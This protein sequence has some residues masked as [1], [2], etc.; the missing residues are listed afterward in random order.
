V[1]AGPVWPAFAGGAATV[2]RAVAV[3][4]R[5]GTRLGFTDHDGELS[6]DGLSFRPENGAALSALTAVTGLG[7]DLG[8]VSG[9]LRSDALSEADLAAGRF[10]GAEV[11]VWLVNWADPAQRT[12]VFRGEI[13]EVRRA[14]QA[15]AAEVRGIGDRLGRPLGRVYQRDCA[16]VLGDAACGVDLDQPQF[17]WTGAVAAQEDNRVFRF[18]AAEAFPE[19]WFERGV[20]RVEDGPAAGLAA[21]IKGDRILAGA[22]RRIELW[23]PLGAAVAPGTAVRLTAGCDRRSATCAAKFANLVNFRGFPD[24]PGEDWLMSYPVPG[25]RHDGGSRRG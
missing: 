6:F 2:A 14:G 20:F 8:E 23:E 12:V 4:C 19:R 7:P 9:V 17:R 5:D 18:A 10:D 13:G 16:A 3:T 22:T 21:T 11:Q 15:F 24:I 1:S 25:G